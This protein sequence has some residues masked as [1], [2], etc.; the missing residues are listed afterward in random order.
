MIVD[1]WISGERID[2]YSDINI[3]HTFQVNDLA[4]VKDRQASLTNAFLI[5]K[6]A[7]NVRIMSGLGIPS[8]TSRIPYQKPS[9]QLRLDGFDLIVKGWLNISETENKNDYK[10]N[11]YSGIINFFKAIENKTLGNDLDLSE[12]NHEKSLATVIASQ[13]NPFY[14]YLIADYNG[15][16][17]YGAS[18]EI[19]NIDYLIPS[20]N[21]KYLWD[22]VH[23]KYGFTYSGSIFSESDFTNLWIT[24]PKGIIETN[25]T[26]VDNRTGT[27]TYSQSSPYMTGMGYFG[28]ELLITASGKYAFNMEIDVS[29]VS[30]V[31]LT[32]IPVKI[33][34][35]QNG[36]QVFEH[37][38]Y[39]LGS[40]TIPTPLL[41]LNSG[42][43]IIF[44]WEW[45]QVG[46]Y[47]INLG[48][49][50]ESLIFDN[51]DYSFNEELREFSIKDFIKEILNKFG[52]T[53]FP[54]EFS[55]HL[56]YDLL[57]ERINESEV[58]DWSSKYIQRT[59]EEYTLGNY[60]RKN[61]FTYQYN[62]KEGSYL[63]GAI[64]INNINL[65]DTR[66]VFQSKTYAPEKD[67]VSF[68]LG[69]GSINVRTFKIY[70]KE[71]E[72][73]QSI[74]YKGLD[75]RF[76]FINARLHS[77]TFDIGSEMADEETTLT[78]VYVGE[79]I[80][81]DWT[82]ILAKYYPDFK[83]ILNDTRVHDIELNLS[84]TDVLLLDLRKRY[85][86]KQEQ[87]YYIL[88]KLNFDDKNATGEFIRILSAETAAIL[89]P[90]EPDV[91]TIQIAW[92]DDT[93]GNKAGSLTSI[94]MK[95][96]SIVNGD[97]ITSMEWQKLNFSWENLSTDVSPYTATLT[98]G[99]N[100]F[101]MKGVT[102]AGN[103]YSNELKYTQTIVPPA[104]CLQ[105]TFAYSGSQPEDIG[106]V[107]YIDCDLI[108]RSLNL[109]FEE[110]GGNYYE[111][112]ICATEIVE[113]SGT[114][115]DI[116]NYTNQQTCV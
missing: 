92:M 99:E 85:W 12:I 87:Q 55:N 62:D 54:D 72:E 18:N 52:L 23:E 94:Q 75:K 22:K 101:R 36:N 13:A 1:I 82:A 79:Y 8:D 76:H 29:G 37:L 58:I 78:S 71:I 65:D 34:I 26:P 68:K 102:G 91:P 84:L 88:N 98:D 69:A 90:D 49:D 16:T 4:D 53:M 96:A 21:A 28:S 95:I 66:T 111:I 100:R 33:K 97:L 20:V 74:T 25:L 42:D 115:T 48:Y 77:A 19:V 59:R 57:T 31:T 89:P 41:N 9:C 10:I 5:P 40:N 110:S 46:T 67:F 7:H 45:D 108:Q 32:G 3:R 60:A 6:T 93:T 107:T 17:H 47:T 39:N 109:T 44:R 104:S 56:R 24:Y 38:I 63:D 35:W 51:T 103:I 86:F 73:D 15:K 61:V 112:T 106:T 80:S 83:R 50:I 11:V 27:V 81:Q 70:D 114:A 43:V 113:V 14:K 30:P 2:M 64:Y 116:T 105:F